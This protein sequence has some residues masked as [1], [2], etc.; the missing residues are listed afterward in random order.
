MG[1]NVSKNSDLFQKARKALVKLVCQTSIQEKL[2]RC[3]HTAIE[4]SKLFSQSRFHDHL[5][6]GQP[7]SRGNL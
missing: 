7:D 6:L 2:N 5:L 4:K 1:T 3:L